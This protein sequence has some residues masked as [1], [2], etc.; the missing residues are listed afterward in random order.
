[1]QTSSQFPRPE[2]SELCLD[3][4]TIGSIKTAS[5][6]QL[7]WHSDAKGVKRG[8]PETG[9]PRSHLRDEFIIRPPHG[10]RPEQGLQIV[11][12]FAAAPVLLSR[13]VERHEDTRVQVDVDFSAE[14]SDVGYVRK[15]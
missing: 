2:F 10:H 6:V 3:T 4:I 5:K 15:Q 11:G 7:L 12:K 8:P 14:E 1:M 9:S 13:W